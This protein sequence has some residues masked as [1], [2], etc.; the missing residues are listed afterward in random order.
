MV[1][2]LGA[3]KYRKV[4]D[5]TFGLNTVNI[6]IDSDND[7]VKYAINKRFIFLVR[8]PQGMNYNLK[9]RLWNDVRSTIANEF[10]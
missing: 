4:I 7:Y 9:N 5:Q 10:L 2:K 1:Y 6:N 3:P 8:H